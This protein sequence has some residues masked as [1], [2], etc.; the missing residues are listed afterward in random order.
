MTEIVCEKCGKKYGYELCGDV[1]PG[2]KDKE[3]ANCPYCGEIGY[4]VM[5]SQVIFVT[6]LEK[7]EEITK[8]E[9][10]GEANDQYWFNK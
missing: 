9:K 1:Y 5:T 8:N 7:D 3:T 2:C 10:E 6:K 4:S